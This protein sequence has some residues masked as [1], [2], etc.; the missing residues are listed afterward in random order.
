MN[1]NEF[2][3]LKRFK[4]LKTACKS[5]YNLQKLQDIDN[6]QDNVT[7]KWCLSLKLHGFGGLAAGMLEFWLLSTKVFYSTSSCIFNWNIYTISCTILVYVNSVQ[8]IETFELFKT[9]DGV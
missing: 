5:K 7:S 9:H 6:I 2:G 8:S 4:P 1:I 3:L